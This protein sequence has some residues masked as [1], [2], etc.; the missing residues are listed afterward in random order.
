[1]LYL[2]SRDVGVK[3]YTPIIRERDFENSDCMHSRFMECN[4]QHPILNGSAIG[5]MFLVKCNYGRRCNFSVM[6]R[7]KGVYVMNGGPNGLR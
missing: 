2:S 4:Y 1:M 6:R 3:S 5:E 7:N